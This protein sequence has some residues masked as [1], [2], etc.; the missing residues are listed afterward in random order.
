LRNDLV[1]SRQRSAGATT[2]IVKDPV[3]GE[4]FRLGEAERFIA[5]QLDGD[6]P[7]DVVRD[8]TAERFGATVSG[9]T[10]TAFV[11]SLEQAGLLEMEG[12]QHRRPGRRRRLRGNLLHLRFMLADPNSVFGRWARRAR[13]LFTSRFVALSAGVILLALCTAISHWSEIT[14]D[15]S[16][17]YTVSAIPMFVVVILL[18]VS[19]HE[20]AHGLVCRHFGGEVHEV[21]FMLIYFQPAFYCNVSDAWLFPEKSKRMWVGFAG[22]YFELFLWAL[23]VLAW[24]VTAVDTWINYLALVVMAS[25]GIKTLLNF[26]P[27][28]KLDGYYLLSDYLGVPNLRRKSFRYVGNLLK[29]LSGGADDPLVGMT[30]RERRIF[31]AYGCTATVASFILLGVVAMQMGSLLID[32]SQPLAFAALVG[33]VGVRFQH[34]LGKLFGDS[35]LQVE[36]ESDNGGPV[37]VRSGSE[38]SRT[39]RRRRRKWMRRVRLLVL[40]GIAVTVAVLGRMELRIAG[41]FTVLPVHNADVRPEIEGFIEQIYVTEG[42]AVRAGDVVARL[43]AHEQR[44]DLARTAADLDQARA[45]LRMMQAGPIQAEIEVAQA[46]VQKAKDRLM[47]AVTRRDRSNLLAESGVLT[48]VELEDTQELAVT[49]QNELAEAQDKLEVV[50]A[51]TR[52]EQIDATK[53]EIARL[54]AEQGYLEGQLQRVEVR[55]PATG[56]VATPARQLREMARQ[57]VARGAL[58]AKVYDLETLTVEI[59]IPEKEIADIHVGYPV[60]FKASAYPNRTFH[61]KVTSIATT[62]GSDKTILVTTEVDNRSLLLKPGMTGRAKVLGGER[63]ISELM[64][65]RLA[66]TVKVEFWSWW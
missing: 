1:V 46:A 57:Q 25:S 33:L 16:R 56:I 6:T 17:L 24:R 42:D 20:L 48:Q 14:S 41:P 5:R 31:L 66:R 23:A 34:R 37:K 53:A 28:I 62:A 39:S 43:A 45:R 40:A 65:R 21:G 49:A 11:Q 51:G 29:R 13:G 9:E 35:T 36:G 22:P 12:I 52:Q 15:L 27:L 26:V 2:L 61:G 38:R 19:A 4:F 55:S 8:R 30:G 63:R 3:S 47:Y 18:V 60:N 44:S 7:L 59:T 32:T 64:T 50:L 58:I 10:V 54:E